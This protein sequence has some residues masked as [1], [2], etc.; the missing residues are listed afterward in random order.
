MD[1]N[2][3]K[4]ESV[5]DLGTYTPPVR[6]E[7]THTNPQ[8]HMLPTV[9]HVTQL[10]PV[11]S[12]LPQ[13]P[14]PSTSLSQGELDFLVSCL[15]Q[16]ACFPIGYGT[17]HIETAGNIPLFEELIDSSD[18]A[19]RPD[20]SKRLNT[21]TGETT[22]AF[23]AST[24][25]METAA[26]FVQDLLRNPQIETC[27]SPSR[28]QGHDFT[29]RRQPGFQMP[30]SPMGQGH[31]PG[32]QSP[33]FEGQISPYGGQSPPFSGQGSQ[34]ATEFYFPIMENPDHLS[35]PPML[36]DMGYQQGQGQSYVQD[37]GATSQG[38]PR[39]WKF[40]L[41]LLEDSRYNPSH[42]V[43]V[44]RQ[45][46]IFRLIDPPR[47]AELWGHVKGNKSMNY[48]KLSRGLR[49]YYTHNV[50]EHVPGKLV[51]KFGP[52]AQ[53]W[54]YLSQPS[55]TMYSRTVSSTVTSQSHYP[56]HTSY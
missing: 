10:I 33:Q 38:Q 24:S 56:P 37:P 2:P 46:G 16:I 23:T 15:T 5:S 12:H 29:Q 32:R 53:V 4:T 55:M 19:P 51:Y 14:E 18:T 7:V 50:L 1:N 40:I 35:S 42:I 22:A 49:Y 25:D 54:Q 11:T 31:Q 26:K 27:H 45:E 28:R 8:F 47:L 21:G 41:D 13:K 20:N 44:N 30:S 39:L 3:V 48:E 52:G 43:W 6:M 9:P 17:E 34:S 36:M